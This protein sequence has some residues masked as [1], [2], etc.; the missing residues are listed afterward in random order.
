MIH[1]FFNGRFLF[2]SFPI[3][4]NKGKD[5]RDGALPTEESMNEEGIH[6]RSDRESSAVEGTGLVIDPRVR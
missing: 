4:L 5:I 2:F 6:D 1:R 3:F